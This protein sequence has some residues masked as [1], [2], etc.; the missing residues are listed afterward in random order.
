VHRVIKQNLATTSVSS[1]ELSA[2]CVS[3]VVDKSNIVEGDFV[4]KDQFAA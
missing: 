1:R 4:P 3:L 2:L